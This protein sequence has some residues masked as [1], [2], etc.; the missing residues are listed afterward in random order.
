MSGGDTGQSPSGELGAPSPDAPTAPPRRPPA[1]P[2]RRGLIVAGAVAAVVAI[3]VAVAVAVTGG[4]EGD[5]DAGED[6]GEDAREAAV[7]RPGP[8]QGAELAVDGDTV[9]ST[10]GRELFCMDAA[11]GE[12]QFSETLPGTA[13]SPALAG[14]TLVVAAGSR[15]YGYSLDGRQ[16]WA[17]AGLQIDN[18]DDADAP[19]RPAFPVAGD[20]VAVTERVPRQVEGI[21]E[22]RQVV[23]IDA[24]SG[25]VAWRA[26]SDAGGVPVARWYGFGPVVADGRRFYATGLAAPSEPFSGPEMTLVALDAATGAEVWR[27][28]L[29]NQTLINAVAPFADGSAVAFAIRNPARVLVVDAATGARRWILRLSSE[30]GSVAHTDGVTIVGDGPE[31]RGYDNEGTELWTASTPDSDED[32][33]EQYPPELDTENGHVYAYRIRVSEIDPTDGTSQTIHENLPATD[34]AVAGG[35]LVIAGDHLETAALPDR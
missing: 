5:D 2:R 11:S 29:G 28:N 24:R 7:L 10:S 22:P 31:L 18:V 34:V 12:E 32:I 35:H 19:A 15:L 20:F 33:V 14:E 25:Q 17:A 23:G 26:L 3:T 8:H 1:P 30:L 4:G 13:T 21:S 9:C 16:L 27:K 6:A